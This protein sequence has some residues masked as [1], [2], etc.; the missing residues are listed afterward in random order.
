[1]R[2]DLPLYEGDGFIHRGGLLALSKPVLTAPAR[3]RRSPLAVIGDAV[4]ELFRRLESHAYR[5]RYRELESYLA[6]SGDVFE[7]E[8]RIR[9][10][11]RRQGAG[12]DSYF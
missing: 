6:D 2:T 11:E 3:F 12:F 7:L 1:M 4:R 8:R 9:N 5:M 10:L